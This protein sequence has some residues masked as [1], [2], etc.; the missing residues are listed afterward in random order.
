MREARF[1]LNQFHH[2]AY[3]WGRVTKFRSPFPKAH[4]LRSYEDRNHKQKARATSVARAFCC[5]SG[6][7]FDAVALRGL[8]QTRNVWL[9]AWRICWIVNNLT[10][11]DEELLVSTGRRID[12]K[13]ARRRIA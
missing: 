11:V 2:S 5:G 9:A 12:H 13:H 4:L 7:H 6:E 10:G 8:Q 3:W 1:V